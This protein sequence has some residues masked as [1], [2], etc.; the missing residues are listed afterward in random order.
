MMG[1]AADFHRQ[2]ELSLL[3]KMKDFYRFGG[4]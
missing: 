3:M 2:D 4:Q 1:L